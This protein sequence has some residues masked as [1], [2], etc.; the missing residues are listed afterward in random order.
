MKNWIKTNLSKIT[1]ILALFLAT[2][3]SIIGSISYHKIN[4]L[5]YFLNH[6]HTAVWGN[7]TIWADYFDSS[8]QKEMNL[9]FSNVSY[10]PN[11][12]IKWDGTY[13]DGYFNN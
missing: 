4:E 12:D 5:T 9:Y 2:I 1:L 10:Q 6:D 7:T 8:G 3:G 13:P 11:H